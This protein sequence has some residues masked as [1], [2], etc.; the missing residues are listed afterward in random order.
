MATVRSWIRTIL[1]TT[2]MRRMRPGPLAPI[3][4]PRRKTT[5]RSY[6]RRIL[7]ELERIRTAR[8]ISTAAETENIASPSLGLP[9]AQP[10][11]VDSI[12]DH[13]RALFDSLVRF[14]RPVLPVNEDPP[15]A[16]RKLGQGNPALSHEP[17]V[18]GDRPSPDRAISR[19]DDEGEE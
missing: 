19:A 6:S 10:Q 13:G 1:S 14:R 2:G 5:P 4:R 18:P 7:I 16:G 15:I 9:Y 11:A 8:K 17:F 3:T 12:D